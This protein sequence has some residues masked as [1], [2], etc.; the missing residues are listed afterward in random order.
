[1]YSCRARLTGLSV[2]ISFVSRARL[3]DVLWS[4]V[5]CWIGYAGYAGY[6]S[7]S[8]Y[9][10]NYIIYYRANLPVVHSHVIHI[11]FTSKAWFLFRNAPRIR[12]PA[13]EKKQYYLSNSL[14]ATSRTITVIF[15]AWLIISP[16]LFLCLLTGM[17]SPT[18]S[19]IPRMFFLYRR[20][21]LLISPF[22][23]IVLFSICLS[24]LLFLCLLFSIYLYSYILSFIKPE[25]ST[26]EGLTSTSVRWYRTI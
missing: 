24:F 2:I 7:S 3:H 5:L 10:Y 14:R 25:I 16:R 13:W 12:T 26:N 19:C 20:F 18:E 8:F 6:E 21:S 15:Q 11:I 23:F 9:L 22:L 17:Y 4:L 1:M